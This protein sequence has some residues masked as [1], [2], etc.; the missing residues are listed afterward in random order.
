MSSIEALYLQVERI[1]IPEQRLDKWQDLITLLESQAPAK[2]SGISKELIL[3]NIIRDTLQT[4]QVD[5]AV[6]I[7]QSNLQGRARAWALVD[8]LNALIKT[9]A[10]RDKSTELV[11]AVR[12]A[13][14]LMEEGSRGDME[15]LNYA[16]ILLL[17][18]LKDG[19][20]YLDPAIVTQ[21]QEFL[22]LIDNPER[23]QHA[24][25][26]IAQFN[27]VAKIAPTEAH[28]Q[29]YD[30]LA[31]QDK[32]LDAKALVN[33]HQDIMARDEFNVA[34]E[35]L[36]AIDKDKERTQA[37]ND[38]FKELF[39]NGE[40]SRALRVAFKADN[41]SK[42]V[43]MFS[44]LA[45]H[46]L[47]Q[48]YTRRSDEALSFA[49]AE[50][51]QLGNSESRA[52]AEKLIAERME[53]ARSNFE[54]KGNDKHPE[55]KIRETALKRLEE[56]GIEKAVQHARTIQDALYRTRTYRMLAE[57]QIHKVDAYNVFSDT[58]NKDAQFIYHP[59][60]NPKNELD[61]ALVEALEQDIAKR[62][63]DTLGS[64]SLLAAPPSEL[65]RKIPAFDIAK[66]M[67]YDAAYVD[68]LVPLNTHAKV[69]QV[70]YENNVYNFK[71][72]SPYGNAGFTEKQKVSSPD[73]LFIQEGIIDFSTFYDS[74][75]A[76]GVTDYIVKE[77]RTYLLR[78]PLLIG[79]HA[80]LVLS[81]D[82]VDTIRLSQDSGAYIINA[83]QFYLT[84][85]RLTAWNE[86]QDAPPYYH[87]LERKREFRPYI[88]AWSGSETYIAGSELTALGYSNSKSYGLSLTWGPRE[89]LALNKKLLE[90]PTG[91][92]VDSSFH[93]AYY[94]FYS[95]EADDVVVVGNEYIDNVIYGIDPHDRSRRLIFAYNTAYDSQKKHGIIISREVNDSFIV[96][97]LSFDNYGTGIMIDRESVNT[98]IYGNTTFGNKQDGIT[99]FESDCNLIAS[100]AVF[101]NKKAGIRT[102]NAIDLGIFYNEF[103]HNKQ[104]GVF[105]YRLDLKSNA[106]QETRDF[107]LDPFHRVAANTI[108]GNTIS[109]N[110]TGVYSD[111]INALTIRDNN[112]IN[113]SPRFIRG[114]WFE[115]NPDALFRFKDGVVMVDTCPYY[116]EGDRYHACPLRE[117]GIF[118]GDGQENVLE[119]LE[120]SA[121]DAQTVKDKG[122]DQQQVMQE[123]PE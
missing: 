29:L 9:G 11:Y 3:R 116:Q 89:V 86:E 76:Q 99:I 27:A 94:G 104:A 60:Y 55:K 31:Q 107:D 100:N 123:V 85:I 46:Y 120:V 14:V 1:E 80:T 108:I 61:P 106:A 21:S 45:A 26:S 48:G 20:A 96:G 44:R 2:S 122:V 71:F 83:G 87:G 117:Q 47:E 70:F 35:C 98:I 57:H 62:N 118:A 72:S 92:V 67:K 52:K 78:R 121:C 74:L 30:L 91:I 39:D 105:S 84:G 4:E 19:Q 8:I 113:Q 43:N 18:T 115:E 59:D 65:G 103:R 53:K 111:P 66:Q 81:P 36:L 40:Y 114:P 6:E 34:L 88:T 38:F 13:L 64:A 12:D 42:R 41:T 51:E 75:V 22:N 109:E 77:G 69:S 82:D 101:D 7:A 28:E 16:L 110:G 17:T 25:R 10:P 54:K 112:F 97:N 79:R 50:L 63:S 24:L 56:E 49:R 95:Y 73:I 23:R 5:A 37:L 68:T 90:R 15:R 119:R 102:R 58:V 32:K 33:L 93:N